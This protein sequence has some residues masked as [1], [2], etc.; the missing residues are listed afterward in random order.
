MKTKLLLGA[1]LS[2]FLFLQTGCIMLGLAAAGAALGV[3]FSAIYMLT[4]YRRTVFGVM[5]NEKLD[6]IKDLT[7]NEIIIFTPLIIATIVLGVFPSLIFDITETSVANIMAFA[8]GQ[9]GS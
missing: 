9:I 6:G 2:G 8:A 4:L 5:T 7:R 1:L 3:I